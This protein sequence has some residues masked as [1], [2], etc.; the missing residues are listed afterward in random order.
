MKIMIA[1]GGRA[2]KRTI[3]S[4]GNRPRRAAGQGRSAGGFT[5]PRGLARDGRITLTG[6]DR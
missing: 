1:A 4:N 6:D 3:A 2:G 5:K